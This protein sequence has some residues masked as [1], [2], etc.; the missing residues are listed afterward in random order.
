MLT[1]D[2]LIITNLITSAC[3]ELSLVRQFSSSGA[4]L[5][6]LLTISE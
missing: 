1:H 3:K 4:G 2:Q 6:I 5:Y